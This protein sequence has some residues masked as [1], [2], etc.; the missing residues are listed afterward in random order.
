[1]KLKNVFTSGKMNK[2]SDERLIQK[3]DCI[4]LS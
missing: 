1:M 2:D 3:G 4:C